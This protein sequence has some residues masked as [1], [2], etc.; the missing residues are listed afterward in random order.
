MARGKFLKS[1]QAASMIRQV[2][3]TLGVRGLLIAAGFISS[4]VTARLLGP[5]GRGVF[6]YWATV[7]SLIVQFG[8]FG[9]QSSNTYF[10]AK[11]RARLVNLST[12]ALLVSIFGG[13]TLGC[14]VFVVRY[15]I[16]GQTVDGWEYAV[17]TVA[18]ACSGLYFMFGSNLLIAL[19]RI[20]AYNKFELA[21]RYLVLVAIVAVAWVLPSAPIL[22]LTSAAI[23]MLV[24]LPLY[25]YLRRLDPGWSP[26]LSLI[27]QGIGYAARAYIITALGF[28]VLRLNTFLLQYFIDDS[29]LGVW[30]IAAQLIDVINVIPSTVALI[31]LPKIM[32]DRDPYTLMRR[33]LWF[34]GGILLGVC[35]LM[36]ILGHYF[37]VQAYGERFAEAYTILL[38]GLPGVFCLGLISIYSQYLASAGM[39]LA[40]AWVWG[41]GLVIEM[42]LSFW[43]IP[44]KGLSGGMISMSCAYLCVLLLIAFVARLVYFNHPQD[45]RV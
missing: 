11:G 21:N 10:L 43:L 31:L 44:I 1:L 8:N 20:S 30:S 16:S 9:L 24:C 35:I 13:L 38:W 33:S 39:P 2:I 22:L 18:L 41:S 23:S 34:V 14:S 29:S 12:N 27:G 19:G 15:L 3:G 37:I 28:M 7:A 4:V 17:A 42:L 36:I 40:Q 32:R 45:S 25:Y 6:F 5:E 26:S